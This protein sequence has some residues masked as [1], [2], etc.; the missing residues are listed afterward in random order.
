MYICRPVNMGET[1]WKHYF[2]MLL[3]STAGN[4][5]QLEHYSVNTPERNLYLSKNSAVNNVLNANLRSTGRYG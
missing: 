3:H 1:S 2:S 5:K 4:G